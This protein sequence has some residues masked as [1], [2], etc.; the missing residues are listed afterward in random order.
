[1]NFIED[2]RR[3]KRLTQVYDEVKYRCKC[4]RRVVIPK[5][6]DKNLCDWCGNYV[7][8][9]KKTEFKYRLKE[10]MNERR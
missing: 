10:K 8:K 5:G 7:F 2:I 4:G 6:V 9:D 3:F 1:M